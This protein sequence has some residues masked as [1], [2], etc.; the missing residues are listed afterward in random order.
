VAK[1]TRDHEMLKLHSCD[2]R[3]GFDSHK[4][5]GTPQHLDAL[6]RFGRSPAHRRSFRAPVRFDRIVRSVARQG[7]E[8][9][10]G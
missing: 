9:K 1:V 2:P 5:Y 8:F 6:A 4:G 3:Y 7:L 10:G